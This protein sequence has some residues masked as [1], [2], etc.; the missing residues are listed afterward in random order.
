MK[1]GVYDNSYAVREF[2]GIIEAADEREAKQ[3][4]QWLTQF[5]RIPRDF[6]GGMLADTRANDWLLEML[7]D[8]YVAENLRLKDPAEAE[9]EGFNWNDDLTNW[10]EVKENGEQKAPML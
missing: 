4:L 5:C 3:K 1:F 7:A 10:W 9:A 2:I 6:K 8:Q